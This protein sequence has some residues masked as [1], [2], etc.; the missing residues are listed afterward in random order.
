MK[1]WLSMLLIV[2][3]ALAVVAPAV[4][5]E[6]DFSGKQITWIIPFRVG[7]GS[8]VWSRLYAPFFQKYLPGDPII[9]ALCRNH[10]A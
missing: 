9:F 3:C 4:Q 2:V 7:G 6:V 8:D 1:K 5:A 10:L